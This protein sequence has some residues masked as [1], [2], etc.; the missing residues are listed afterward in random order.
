MKKYILYIVELNFSLIINTSMASLG[1]KKN[2]MYLLSPHDSLNILIGIHIVKLPYNEIFYFTMYFWNHDLQ[3]YLWVHLS[4]YNE[5][6][7]SIQRMNYTNRFISSIV[8]YLCWRLIIFI[9]YKMCQNQKC[10][11]LML[12]KYKI[13][14][15]LS[16]RMLRN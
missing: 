10:S 3:C 12:N 9:I 1:V 4:L 6:D 14:T 7:V 11:T 15:V 8:Q 16:V 13:L 2:F 5:F